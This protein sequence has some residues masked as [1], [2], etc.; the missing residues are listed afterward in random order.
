MDHLLQLSA[1]NLLLFGISFLID[2][3]VL[4]DSIAR[5][6]Q[7]HAFA[8]QTVAAR[9]AG[10]LIITFDVLGQIVMDDKPDIGFVD[11]HAESDCGTDDS[12]FISQEKF[13]VTVALFRRQTGMIWFGSDPICAKPFGQIF[14]GLAG[15]AIN[16]TAFFGPTFE[17]IVQ[18]LVRLL[19]RQ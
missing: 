12:H 13:L 9:A 19:F 11:A 18:L 16:D 6:E 15:L 1:S 4:L 5:I 3:L 17:E 10:F 8:G 14:S 7:E 2:E